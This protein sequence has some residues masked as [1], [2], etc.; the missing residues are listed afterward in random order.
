VTSTGASTHHGSVALYLGALAATTGRSEAAAEH[1]DN[2]LEAHA[3][4]GAKPWEAWTRCEYGRML[5]ARGHSNDRQQAE[6]LL[7]DARATAQAL[8]MGGLLERINQTRL[9]A[10]TRA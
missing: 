1:L 5:L 9:D 2:A 6:R 7:T 3:R 10:D 4:M 8:G